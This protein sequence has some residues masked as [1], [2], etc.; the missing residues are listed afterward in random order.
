MRYYEIPRFCL[1]PAFWG[2]SVHLSSEDSFNISTQKMNT[3]LIDLTVFL[4]STFYLSLRLSFD[5]ILG[6]YDDNLTHKA[7]VKAS[8]SFL[9]LEAT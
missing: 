1:K 5:P 6:I 3:S 9:N 2:V 4:M 8:T 7:L